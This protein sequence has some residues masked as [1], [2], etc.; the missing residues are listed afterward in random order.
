MCT[1][2]LLFDTELARLIVTFNHVYWQRFHPKQHCGKL[3]GGAH[4]LYHTKL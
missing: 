1:D 3:S 4:H 2:K